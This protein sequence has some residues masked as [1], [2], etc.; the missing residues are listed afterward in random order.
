MTNPET[1]SEKA[2]RLFSTVAITASMLFLV[3]GLMAVLAV[4][5]SSARS[6]PWITEIHRHEPDDRCPQG[7]HARDEVRK[8]QA[9]FDGINKPAEAHTT[10][11]RS[12]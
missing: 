3:V 9:R 4:R 8:L 11:R 10:R 1:S 6:M 2:P 7:E 5:Y 12:C